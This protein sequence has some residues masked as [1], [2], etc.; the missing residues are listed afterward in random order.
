MT[1]EQPNTN[2]DQTN[3]EVVTQEQPQGQVTTTEKQTDPAEKPKTTEQ[4][5]PYDR[6][7]EKVDEANAL[8]E[9]LAKY[10]EAEEAKKLAE[11]SEAER[12]KAEAD[13]LRAQLEAFK[14]DALKA[15]KEALLAKAGYTAEQVDKYVK[16][17]VGDTDEAL[18]ASLKEL[19]AD[20]SPKQ[21]TYADP[22]NAGGGQRPKAQ[23]K[24]LHDKGTSVYQRL[25][26]LKRI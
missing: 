5:I 12:A 16:Y 8:K 17:L 25:K 21:K 19:V 4:A 23:K 26:S 3:P 22:A 6:F 9:Q 2:G 20:I 10:Q 1:V 24:D 14:G 11:L 13:K 18:E 15:K 7:K